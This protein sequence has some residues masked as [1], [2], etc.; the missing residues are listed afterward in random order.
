MLGAS[1]GGSFF[2]F[3]GGGAGASLT[4]LAGATFAGFGAL[5]GATFTALTDFVAFA[6]TGLVA[7]AAFGAVFAAF[8]AAAFGATLAADFAGALVRGLRGLRRRRALG[9][10]RRLGARRGLRGLGRLRGRCRPARRSCARSTSSRP[11][12]LG[13]PGWRSSSW[14]GRRPSSPWASGPSGST[15][16]RRS[17]ADAH[18]SVPGEPAAG[19]TEASIGGTRGPT[20]SVR[21]YGS[22]PRSCGSV[23]RPACPSGHAG[24]RVNTPRLRYRAE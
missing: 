19:P 23:A 5:T 12:P 11:R 18:P 20:P 21:T 22:S 7:L 14:P 17:S 10:L 15:A 24:N 6:G 2:G 16:G 4:T 13:A 9:R 1:G 8:G 3:G